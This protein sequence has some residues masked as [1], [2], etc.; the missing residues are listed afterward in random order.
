[1]A[2]IKPRKDLP[3]VVA[4]VVRYGP[5]IASNGAATRFLFEIFAGGLLRS[6]K[7]AGCLLVVV[8]GGCGLL[9]YTT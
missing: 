2:A 7:E 6:H 9:A 4:P 3:D 1:M 5:R 8:R